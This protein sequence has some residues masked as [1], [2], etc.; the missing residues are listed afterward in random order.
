MTFY[1]ITF[2]YLSRITTILIYA[3]LMT[4]TKAKTLLTSIESNLDGRMTYTYELIKSNSFKLQMR[5][6]VSGKIRNLNF[7][8]KKINGNSV[9]VKFICHEFSF[10]FPL[11]KNIRS[12]T[13]DFYNFRLLLIYGIKIEE[14]SVNPEADLDVEF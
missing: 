13:F 12:M 5:D 14:N 6:C 3:S 10:N 7:E 4:F 2:L 1:G 8:L 11:K 9:E